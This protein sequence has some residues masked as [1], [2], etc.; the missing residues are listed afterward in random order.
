MV[1]LYA[2][3]IAAVAWIYSNRNIN[4]DIP[5]WFISIISFLLIFVCLELF[6]SCFSNWFKR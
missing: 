4:I 5:D 6:L 3:V 1:S 2:S